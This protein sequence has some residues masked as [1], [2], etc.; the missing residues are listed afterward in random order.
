MGH[1]FQVECWVKHSDG[2]QRILI[3]GYGNR[4]RQSG[5]KCHLFMKIKKNMRKWR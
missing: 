3:N 5:I 4:Q 1:V 2:Y